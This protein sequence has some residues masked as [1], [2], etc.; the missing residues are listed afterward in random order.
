M[1][2]TF[3]LIILIDFNVLFIFDYLKKVYFT[4]PTTHT[5]VKVFMY[6]LKTNNVINVVY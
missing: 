2:L 3:L 4:A 6:I 1:Y 5:F